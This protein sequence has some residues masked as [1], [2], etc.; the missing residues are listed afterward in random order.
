MAVVCDGTPPNSTPSLALFDAGL[1]PADSLRWR[2]IFLKA[3]LA[4]SD[5]PRRRRVR[6]E[7][8]LELRQECLRQFGG[9]CGEFGQPR[10]RNF[11]SLFLPHEEFA[12]VAPHTNAEV[13]ANQI[14]RRTENVEAAGCR[15]C[16]QRRTRALPRA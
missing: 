8:R 1:A 2:E 16:K 4:R 9:E 6:R 14:R 3:A 11:E 5:L 15:R 12:P 7:N 10:M 13:P